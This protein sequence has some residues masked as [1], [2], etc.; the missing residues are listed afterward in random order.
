[1]KSGVDLLLVKVS[2]ILF[3]LQPGQ[4]IKAELLSWCFGEQ[5]VNAPEPRGG[6]VL[7]GKPLS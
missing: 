5:V 6:L 4:R 1:M 2:E 3:L 7:P